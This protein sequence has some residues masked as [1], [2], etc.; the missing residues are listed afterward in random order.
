MRIS[1][2]C[3]D[4]RQAAD[5]LTITCSNRITV[6]NGHQIYGMGEAAD[7]IWQVL[8]GFVSLQAYTAEGDLALMRLVAA[9]GVF[10]YRSFISDEPRSTS[11]V[12]IGPCTLKHIPRDLLRQLLH[13]EPRLGAALQ[14]SMAQTLRDANDRILGLVTQNC[15]A[16]TLRLLEW[17]AYRQGVVPAP[18]GFQ[19]ITP[20]PQRDIARIIGVTPESLS[21]ALRRL[22]DAGIVVLAGRRIEV[23]DG[24]DSYAAGERE[25]LTGPAAK[26]RSADRSEPEPRP[27]RAACPP[28]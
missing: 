4:C 3:G 7:G 6:A 11:A 18:A 28:R 14:L 16:K 10:G 27:A 21:R 2:E 12:A 9:R 1:R 24:W 13:R 5:C 25:G 20:F 8:D 19:V 22:R 23:N 17:L 26:A 15:A